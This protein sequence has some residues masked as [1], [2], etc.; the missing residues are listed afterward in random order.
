MKPSK[1]QIQ[2]WHDDPKNWK[3][4]TIYY[5]TEDPRALVKKRIEWM[6]WTVNFA[7]RKG[8]FI[9]FVLTVLIILMMVFLPK[10]N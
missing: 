7:N 4:S 5:N 2:Q 10:K 6:G 8:I 1:E 3:W 9:F